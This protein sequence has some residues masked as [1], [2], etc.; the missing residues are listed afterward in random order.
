MSEKKVKVVNVSGHEYGAKILMPNGHFME[1]RI[2]AG[3]FFTLNQEQFLDMYTTTRSFKCGTLSFD[4]NELEDETIDWLSLSRDEISSSITLLSN[5][6]I[7]KLL[8]GKALEFDKFMEDMGEIE[9]SDAHSFYLRIFETASKIDTLNRKR[10]EEIEEIT[11]MDLKLNEE[12][13]E[14]KPSK[15]SKKSTAKK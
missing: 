10:A 15:T 1:R 7:T 3:G 6:E 13:A 12:I 5:G 8:K 9:K 4:I 2:R 14:V 11:G